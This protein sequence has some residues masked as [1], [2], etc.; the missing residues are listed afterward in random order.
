MITQAIHI[1]KRSSNF[2][3][4]KWYTPFILLI[5]DPLNFTKWQTPF[6]FIRNF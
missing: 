6:I 5:R 3:E 4:I 1:D 2:V